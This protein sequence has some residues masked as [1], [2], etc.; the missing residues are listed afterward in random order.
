MAGTEAILQEITT[1]RRHFGGDLMHLN[2][3]IS[4][5]IYLPRLLFGFH[6]L[7][8]IRGQETALDLHHFYNADPF[9][10]PIT[11]FFRRPVVYS[12]SSGVGERRP[13]VNYFNS[14]A[15]V[16][17]SDERSLKRLQGWGVR[18]GH[19]VR[20]GINTDRF[21]FT[22]QPLQSEIQLMFASAPWTQRQFKTK[23]VLAL[24][25]AVRHTPELRLVCIW[26]GLLLDELLTQT[27]RM[28]VLPQVEV[29]NRHVDI[30]GVLAGVHGT[31]NLVTDSAVI[32]SYP[33][34]LIE[35][36]A[37]GKPVI[38]SRT[39]PMA[40]Y[41]E[42]TGCGVV[43]ENVTPAEIARAVRRLAL[44]YDDYQTAARQVGRHDFS[45][46]SLVASF[47]RV[48]EHVLKRQHA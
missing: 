21:T 48:Y 45:T 30:N 27:R 8:E 44:D 40:D 34:S 22:P 10:F 35:S 47:K 12:I 14:L 1:L 16:T 38:V 31:V 43:V 28:G 9:P 36:L 25:E 17:V 41:V 19:L 6:R 5:P 24:L 42:R 11:G 23:G 3:N 29:I 13:F 2:P 46:G 18:N 20:P 37:A 33:H 15:A 32:R 39:I 26:R 7:R 4:S